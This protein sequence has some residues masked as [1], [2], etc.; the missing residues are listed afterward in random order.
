[1]DQPEGFVVLGK[2]NLVCK[3]KKSLYGLKQSPRQWYKKFDSFMLSNGFKRSDYDSC[4]YLKTVNGSAIYLLLYVD[5]M[6][7]AAK[8]KSEIAK[9][10]AQ[11]NKE[12]EMKDLGAAKKILGY[13]EKVLRRF[14]MHNAKPVST[15]LAAH[16]RL[17]SDLCPQSDDDIEYMSRVP[18]SKG[19]VGSLMYAMVCSRPNLSHALSVV[20]R[21]MANPGKEHWRA[22]QR[23]FG[24]L[25]GTSSACLQFGKSRD[26]LVGYVDSDHAGDL[27]KRRSLTGYVFIVGGCAVS[28]KGCLQATVALSTTEAEYMAISKLMFHER[29]K[30]IDV[31]YHF[32]RGVIAEGSIKVRKISTHDNPADM[33]TKHVPTS[34]FELCSS[35]VGIKV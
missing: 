6:L 2:E 5:D 30:H 4:V 10:K 32:I 34:K 27:D 28:W 8:E 16:F 22:V 9:L 17:S 26:G 25:R 1:M 18:Y 29:T 19:A 24:Y 3:L 23:I 13:I 31:R 12:F 33:M 15:P 20:G 21:Y 14:N 35:L 11:L 7:I